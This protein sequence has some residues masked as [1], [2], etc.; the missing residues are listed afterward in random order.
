MAFLSFKVWQQQLFVTL[1]D[2]VHR[3][4]GTIQGGFARQDPAQ[5]GNRRRAVAQQ[6]NRPP[7]TPDARNAKLCPNLHT[8]QDLWEEWEFGVGGHKP[9]SRFD[10]Q[11]RSGQGSKGKKQ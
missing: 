11:E 9:A 4:G 1:N 6:E 10:S 2:N 3:F 5:G 7:N 8:L